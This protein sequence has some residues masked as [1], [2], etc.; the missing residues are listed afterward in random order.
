MTY[1]R[2]YTADAPARAQVDAWRGA[3]G[4][5]FDVERAGPED[6]ATR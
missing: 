1:T 3:V 6:R 5:V 4:L 2:S